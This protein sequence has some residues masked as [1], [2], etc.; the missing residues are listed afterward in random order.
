MTRR[1][2]L[3]AMGFA[4]VTTP[5]FAQTPPLE[6]FQCY[7]VLRSDPLINVPLKLRD[8]FEEDDVEA[9]RAR[10]FCNPAGKFHRNQ[11][12]P[13]QDQRQH[14]TF[15]ATFPQASPLRLVQLSNQFDRPDAPPP[16]WRVREAV[17]LAVPTHKPPHDRPEGLDH[18]RCYAAN[19]QP[20]FEGV[21]LVDQFL[22]ALGHFVLDPVLFCNPVQKTR[23]DT[24]EV[25]PIKNPDV[26]MA[27]YSMT[28]VVFQRTQTI[29]N[30]F[31]RQTFAL[32]PPDTICVPTRKISFTEIPDTPVGTP[33]PD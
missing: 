26:H 1:L 28:R 23:V 5:L 17:A 14:L 11:F 12:F 15:Y 19:G 29:E 31:G 21:G 10:R 2:L 8:Q 13:I 27:C 6:H 3:G 32:G 20:A 7:A 33:A 4:A 25:T 9:L 16:T 24:G 30:Q 18:Y 22:P